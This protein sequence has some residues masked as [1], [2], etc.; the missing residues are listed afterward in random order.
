[1][2]HDGEKKSV[3]IKDGRR[4]MT[5]EEDKLWWGLSGEDYKRFVERAHEDPHRVLG[6]HRTSEGV[7]LRVWR[8]GATE[9]KVFIEGDSEARVLKSMRSEG[10]FGSHFCGVETLGAWRV[11]ARGEDRSVWSGRDPYGF[12]PTWG[13]LDEYLF[14]EGKHL[15]M[16]Q[17]LGAH[18]VTLGGVAG[19]AFAVWAPSARSVSVIGP[20]NL[21]DGRVHPMRRL[22]TTG[23]W[24][25]F[26]PELSV[27]VAYQFEVVTAEGWA[28]RKLDPCAAQTELRPST[29]GLVSGQSEHAWEDQA[30][31]KSRAEGDPLSRPVSIYEVHLGSWRRVPEEGD[32]WLTYRE[33][34]ERLADYVVKMGFTHVE[35]LPLH[36]HPFDGSWGYQ[37]TGYFAPTSRFGT[38]D[39]LRYLVD[40]LH[41]RGVGV[42]VDWVPGHFPKDPHG[43]ARFDGTALYEHLDPR[44]AEQPDWGTLVFNFGRAEVKNFLIANARMWLEEFHFD[45]L[46]VDA[47]ASMLYLDYSRR[48][49]EWLPNCYGGRE[50]LE[51][52]AFVRELNERLHAEFAGVMVIAEESTAW[53][54]VSRPVY[55]G[56]LGFTMKWNLGWMHDTLDYFSHDPV[57]RQWHHRDLT[58]GI[59]YQ[60]S[61]NFVIA[62]S[63]DEVVHGK[64]SLIGK[65]HGD[66]WQKFAN[67]RAL[68]G[69]MWCHPGRKLLFMGGEF[70]QEREWNHD[71][72][73][74]WHLCDDPLHAGLSRLIE[75][76]NGLYRATPALYETERDPTAFGW[77]TVDDAERS[78]LAFTRT[79]R[80]K[81]IVLCVLNAT[82]VM[83]TGY[84]VTVPREGVWREVINTDSE[85][86]GGS[87]I[88]NAGSALARPTGE[89]RAELVLTLPPLGVLVF[90][91]TAKTAGIEAT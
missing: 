12:L 50:N 7:T 76:L 61:E 43:L 66:R 10:L 55:A 18:A 54:G 13:E 2:P 86:Y 51:A 80:E 87:N 81:N 79:D 15:R 67:L 90:V 3:E 26:V 83:R 60:W 46:R 44:R 11:E 70:G 62:L 14:R 63:H 31:L 84:T 73:L 23:V 16:Y 41:Q 42:I 59:T 45:G 4:E 48:E 74:D 72:S 29:A 71:R 33:T 24:E 53:P 9:V 49:G 35:F 56:G 58:F 20:W 28:L 39:E 47:V 68:Y 82:P 30:W 37:V 22:G 17:R 85:R 1:M 75:D 6:A 19:V 89:K 36:E 78:V 27:G 65:M 8:P 32:R 21:W 69:W 34:A 57:H 25:L 88:G 64:G 5:E 40:R 77:R 38:P 91:K 52:M